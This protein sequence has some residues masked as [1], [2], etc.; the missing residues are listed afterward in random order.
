[1]TADYDFKGSFRDL[2]ARHG[3]GLRGPAMALLLALAPAAALATPAACDAP[4]YATVLHPAAHA[5]TD[6]R[7][8][9]LDAQFLKWPGS[10]GPGSYRI[11][12][13]AQARLRAER[14]QPV[15]GADDSIEAGVPDTLPASLFERFGFVA[16]GVELAVTR[17]DLAKVPQFLT[18]QMLLVQEDEAGRVLDATHVQ[19]PGA[20]DN[21]YARA[22]DDTALGVSATAARTGFR[23]W[24]PTAQAVAL[25]LY[26]D[27]AGPATRTAPL[28]RDATTGIWSATIAADLRSQYYTYLVDV[29]VPGVGVVRNRVTDPYSIGLT[30]DSKR[31]YIAD[32]DDPALTPTGWDDAPRPAPLAAQTD[33]SIYELHVRDFSINDASVPQA[34]RGKYLAFT[35]TTSNGM[36]HLRALREAGLSDIHLLPVFDIATIPESGCVAPT[37][38]AAAP[39]SEAQQAAVMAQAARDCFNWGYDPYH[40]SVPEGSYASDA[41]DAAVR[42]REFRAMVMALHAAGLRVGMDVVYN[43]TTVAGQQERSVLDRIVPGYYQRLDAEGKVE[44]ST[45]CANTATEHLMM[46]RLMADSVALWARQYRIDSFRFDLMGHQPRAAMEQVQQRA[47]AAAGRPINLIGEGWNFGEIADGK[48]FV[49]ASQLSLQDSGIGTFS[50]RARD[51]LRGG[52]CCDSGTDLV[53]AQ[54]YLNGLF[55]APN[56]LSAG[57]HT[58][59]D[60]LRAADF[61]R[62]GLAGTLRDYRLQ[63]ADGHEKPL[64]E[65][66]YKGQPAG[67]AAQ[68]AEVVNYVENHDNQTLFDIDAMKLPRDTAPADRARVQ[69]LGAAFVAFSQ[70]VAYFHAGMDVLRSKSLDRNSFDSGD[71]FNRL[72]WSYQDNHYGTGLPPA[73]DNGKDWAL[74]RPMLADT[75]TIKPTPGDIAFMR[76]GFRDLLRIRASSSLFR[77]RTAADV[78]Q[79]LRFRNTGRDQNP[80]VIAAHLD[81]SGYNGANFREVLYLLNVAPQAQTL[82]LP[83]EAGKR[84]VLHPVQRAA[85]AAD[86]RAADARFDAREGRFVVPP[87]TAV[88]F[89]VE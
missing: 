72:D 34:H 53:T 19:A 45:C 23:L 11:Y 83:E 85:S 14:G 17:K 58:R 56:S 13:S 31:S 12:H 59:T 51:A 15:R 84:Y 24:A 54:G 81:G 10:N 27:G 6:A 62:I 42:I 71:W 76:D 38:P 5:A 22:A 47:D 40:Y 89:V 77:L 41:G 88:V 43:H 29:F 8:Y 4:G 55:Y 20:L 9:W 7:A 16:D 44:R 1:M 64:S 2:A 80:L 70:G 32:L 73:P 25:C 26:G 33:M 52:G 39:D 86:R 30:T 78:Q 74:L 3:R 18:G 49:Q 63:T 68:P 66:D 82:V 75:E 35:D 60:L 37:V 36:R 46:A 50:D 61:A 28:Q 87:R 69:L 65:I 21:L 67:Y 57:K 79:R 48:R